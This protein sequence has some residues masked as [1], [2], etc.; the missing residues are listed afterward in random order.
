LKG[1]IRPYKIKDLVGQKFTKLTVISLAGR[2]N[3][4]TRWICQCDCGKQKEITSYCLKAG[5]TKSCGC[6]KSQKRS[7][8]INFIKSEYPFNKLMYR[9]IKRSQNENIE[10]SLTT[11]EFKKLTK[12]NCYF[13]KIEPKQ[14]VKST[15]DSYLYNGIDRIDNSKGYTT[16]NVVTCCKDCNN[17]K[18]AITKEMIIKLYNFFN[19]HLG[20]EL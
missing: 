20:G 4:K 10:F 14:V 16:T 6:L 5:Y 17:K 12:E 7:I 19:N 1:V 13:C 15:I 11:D 8:K 18:G 9:Y 3:G 2:F